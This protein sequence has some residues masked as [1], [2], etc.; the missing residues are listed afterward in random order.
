MPEIGRPAEFPARQALKSAPQNVFFSAMALDVRGVAK[1]LVQPDG[2]L[3][4]TTHDASADF[5]VLAQLDC[6]HLVL[7][8]RRQ[9]PFDLA[10]ALATP[11]TEEHPML[12]SADQ[13]HR[14]V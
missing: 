11:E 9:A 3:D 4:K 6:G 10:Q 8:T 7:P 13:K 14:P 5:L 12:F 1:C 2:S